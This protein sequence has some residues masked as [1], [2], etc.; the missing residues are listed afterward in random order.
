MTGDAVV[1]VTPRS[2]PEADAEARAR[3]EGS[4]REVRYNDLGRP[5]RAAELAE[6]VTDVDG[7]LAGVDELDA[8]VFAAAA[9]CASSRATASASTASTWPRPRA[10]ASPSRRPRA[11][12]PPRWRS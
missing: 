6:R 7:L 5:L 2:F 11:R 9:G 10:T 12:T 3:L 4:V 8:S 1:L